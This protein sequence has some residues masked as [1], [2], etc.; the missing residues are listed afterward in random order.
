MI[1]FLISTT[2]KLAQGRL[3]GL[4]S[5]TVST[6]TKLTEVCQVIMV[7]C[8][9]QKDVDGKIFVL[10]DGLQICE[11]YDVGNNSEVVSLMLLH[12]SPHPGNGD[13]GY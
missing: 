5:F 4:S 9:S 7:I 8:R 3:A 11:L 6:R 2:S 12:G 1:S 10:L 13:V